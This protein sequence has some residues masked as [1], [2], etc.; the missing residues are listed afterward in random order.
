MSAAARQARGPSAAARKA[1]GPSKAISLHLKSRERER[2]RDREICPYSNNSIII[3]GYVAKVK[4]TSYVI[5]SISL[6]FLV[7]MCLYN[8]WVI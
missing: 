3:Y 7:P 1:S 5:V 8:T 6:K 2:E 4:N